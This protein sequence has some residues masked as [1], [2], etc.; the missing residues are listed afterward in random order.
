M[1]V[2]VRPLTPRGRRRSNAEIAQYYIVSAA[3]DGQRAA[4]IRRMGRERNAAAGSGLPGNG[5]VRIGEHKL[6]AQLDLATNAKDH[7]AAA[8]GFHGR[9]QAAWSTVVEVR[10]LQDLSAASSDR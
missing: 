10:D 6:G 5:D 7:R 3:F 8:L 2:V 9:P 1:A 4:R